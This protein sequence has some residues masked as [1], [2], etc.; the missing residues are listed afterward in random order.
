MSTSRAWVL[1]ALLAGM[2]A[3]A[4]VAA[5]VSVTGSITNVAPTIT[6]ISLSGLVSGALSPTA[7]TTTSTTATVVATDL[8]GGS[9][10]TGVTVGI[11]KPDGSTVHLA[12][13]AGTLQ[14]SSGLTATF[15]K[16]LTMNYYDAAAL[17]GSTYKI[18]AT[19]TDS[20]SATG[21]N[22]LNLALAT[23]NYNQLVALSAP[24][25]LA[26]SSAAGSSSGGTALSVNNYGNVQID[27]QVSGTSLVGPSSVTLAV[28][29]VTYSLNSGMSGPT[30]L[31]GSAATI[32]AYDLAPANGAAKSIYFDL[33]PTTPAGGLPVGDY[34]GTLTVTAVSG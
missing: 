15:T 33:T 19:A 26:L 3:L 20:A 13:A 8:N 10:I 31:T 16:V 14:S 12:E 30:A 2:A 17:A 18:K 22:V 28:G 27:T 1:C 6:S 24:S 21:S 34:T 5:G 29:D 25:S 32:S 9:D 7:G 23:F 4:P 11:I